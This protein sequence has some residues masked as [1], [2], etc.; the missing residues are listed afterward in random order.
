[1]AVIPKKKLKIYRF[2]FLFETEYIFWKGKLISASLQ[3]YKTKFKKNLF[4]NLNI[5]IL[6]GIIIK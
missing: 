6:Y 5:F 3:K 1:M 2:F 4:S